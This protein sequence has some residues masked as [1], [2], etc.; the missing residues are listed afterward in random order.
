MIHLAAL[1]LNAA[2]VVVMT[3]EPRAASPW[4]QSVRANCGR[5]SLVLT[6]YGAAQPLS[7][8]PTLRVNGRPVVGSS[9]G[10]LLED[11]AH[12]RAAYRLAM[13]CNGTNDVTMLIYVGERLEDGT[14][15]HQSA[16]ASIRGNRLT[17]YTGL[18]AGDADS[19]WFR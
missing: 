11:L 18:R 9:V 5:A 10:R 17:S 6:G 4:E 13:L 14:I 19:F 1:L 2:P 12:R 8:V 16:A 15:R 7:R 3:R